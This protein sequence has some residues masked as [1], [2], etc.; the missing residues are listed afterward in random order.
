MP[1]NKV[2]LDDLT[3]AFVFHGLAQYETEVSGFMLFYAGHF[4]VT[5]ETSA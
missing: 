4:V 1:L 5:I 2:N 3:H